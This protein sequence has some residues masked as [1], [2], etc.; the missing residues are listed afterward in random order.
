MMSGGCEVEATAVVMIV[1]LVHIKDCEEW[2]EGAY[3]Q[4]E[5][6]IRANAPCPLLLQSNLGCIFGSLQYYSKQ[7]F[8]A[9]FIC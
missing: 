8:M 5:F 3:A 2:R 9:T 1:D 4:D 6:N 7:V